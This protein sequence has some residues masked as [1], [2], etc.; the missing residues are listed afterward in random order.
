MSKVYVVATEIVT[1]E[2]FESNVESV[3]TTEQKARERMRDAIEE[4]FSEVKVNMEDYFEQDYD[5]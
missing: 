1:F 4:L 2:M 5:E 3:C